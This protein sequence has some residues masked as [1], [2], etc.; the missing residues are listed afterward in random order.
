MSQRG[1]IVGVDL[2]IGSDVYG[3]IIPD[4]EADLLIGF[5]ALET[6]RAL[7]RIGKNT[8]VLMST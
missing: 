4:G 2:R 5:E 7:S 3:P 6:L 1:G 8:T